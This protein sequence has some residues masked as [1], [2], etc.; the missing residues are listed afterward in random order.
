[1]LLA[2]FLCELHRF[3]DGEAL[4][5]KSFAAEQQPATWLAIRSEL[6]C[7]GPHN[8]NRQHGRSHV[9]VMFFAAVS[10]SL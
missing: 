2:S 1:M 4:H 3:L 6:A 10:G 9:E 5:Q 7:V 8:L